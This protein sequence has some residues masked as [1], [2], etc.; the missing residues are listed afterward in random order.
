MKLE[1]F[2]SELLPH[3]LKTNVLIIVYVQGIGGRWSCVG[4]E[5]R[6]DQELV[7]LASILDPQLANLL[8]FIL[9]KSLKLLVYS[10]VK[11]K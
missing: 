10:S 8:S 2:G 4:I 1:T 9:H 3:L 7:I 5:I 6:S 11:Q